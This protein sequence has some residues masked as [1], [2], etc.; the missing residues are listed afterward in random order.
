MTDWSSN[1]AKKGR[2]IDIIHITKI[3]NIERYK[4]FRRGK[5]QWKRDCQLKKEKI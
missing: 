3:N 4:N 5:I 2:N 1:K